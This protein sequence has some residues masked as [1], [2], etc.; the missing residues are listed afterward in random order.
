[1][2]KYEKE[3]Q[4]YLRKISVDHPRQHKEKN[5]YWGDY[6]CI[7]VETGRRLKYTLGH[8]FATWEDYCQNGYDTMYDTRFGKR[9]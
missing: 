1:M 7:N 8:Y 5:I 6:P 9:E 3:Y 4:Y 2:R